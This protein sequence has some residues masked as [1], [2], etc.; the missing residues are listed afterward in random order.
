MRFADLIAP[1]PVE[2][3]MSEHYGQ[4]PLHIAASGSAA[5]TRLIDWQR[6]NELLAIRSHW[7]EANIKL[8]INSRPVYP[9]LYFEDVET[10]EGPVKRASA[11]KVRALLA[12]GASLVA[13]SVEDIS[14][15][16]RA[17]ASALGEQFAGKA[18]ANIYCSFEGVQAFASHC[19]L[20]EVF[21]IQCEGEK[22]WNIYENRALTPVQPLLGDD[23]QA[24]IDS[25]KGKVALNVRMQP[26]DLLYIPRGFYHDALAS[27]DASLHVTLAVLPLTGRILLRMLE[28]EAVQDPE[29]REYLPDARI[30]GGRVLAERLSVLADRLAAILRTPRFATDVAVRQRQLRDRDAPF[31]LPDRGSA[32]FY[33]RSDREAEL[34]RED[35]GVVLVAGGTTRELRHLH[36]PAEWVLGQRAFSAQQ[37][38][39]EF[40]HVDEAE[41]DGLV[42]DLEQLRLIYRYQPER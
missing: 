41:L 14:P 35:R 3:F 9:N 25:V 16:I 42:R 26:G 4:R 34:R 22:S 8:I 32:D 40:R 18:G 27:R 29:F 28:E 30:D 33:A 12:T 24:V 15:E 7:T 11:A 13:D 38:A 23:A 31:T 6:M 10:S 20:H 5:R 39:A 21:A 17:V 1:L 2:R 19:D 37:L 36:G